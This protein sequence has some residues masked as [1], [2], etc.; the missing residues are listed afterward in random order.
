MKKSKT[1]IRFQPFIML[2]KEQIPPVKL[3]ERA[4]HYYYL[5]LLLKQS[6]VQ[7]LIQS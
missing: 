3:E 7:S 1:S 6:D 4:N 5:P 2:K